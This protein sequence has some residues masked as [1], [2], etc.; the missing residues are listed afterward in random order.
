M[1]NKV[2]CHK[3]PFETDPDCVN[4]PLNLLSDLQDRSQYIETMQVYPRVIQ[5]GV[6]GGSMSLV[7]PKKKAYLSSDS[8][9][10]LPLTCV[11]TGFQLVPSAGIS[12]LIDSAVMRTETGGVIAQ[13]QHSSEL[14]VTID[15]TTPPQ[16]RSGVDSVHHGVSFTWEG[17][18]GSKMNANAD[19]R[20]VLPGQLRL[21][22]DNYMLMSPADVVGR[23][24]C[25]PNCVSAKNDLLLATTFENTPEFSITLG[26]L[27]PGFFRTHFQF[28]L[29]LLAEEVIIDIN[30]SQNGN[31]GQNDR[32]VCAPDLMQATPSCITS[33]GVY[34]LGQ[35]P[36]ALNGTVDNVVAP[37]N[38]PASRGTG[39]RIMV[40]FKS[41]GEPENIRI[42]DAGV[43][44]E[45]EDKIVFGD[46]D[47]TERMV[48]M[49][50]HN[51]KETVWE[52]NTNFLVISGGSDFVQGDTYTVVNPSNP[53]L[54]FKIVATNVDEG[55]LVQC[56]LDKVETN[57]NLSLPNGTPEP[58]K[59][60]KADGTS[61]GAY[62]VLASHIYTITTTDGTE[63]FSKGTELFVQG[64]ED[65][66]IV[67]YVSQVDED[68]NPT[69][70]YV[71]DNSSFQV[72]VILVEPGTMDASS[73]E[74]D[75]IVGNP[76][77][78]TSTTGL[79]HDPVWSFDTYS[80][81]R[82]NLVTGKVSLATDLVFYLNGKTE[83]DLD[84]ML[85]NGYGISY[86]QYVDVL[87]TLSKNDSVDDY[88]VKESIE[89]SRQ[90]GFSNEV[91]RNI[92]F[93]VSPSGTQPNENFPYYN[94]PKLNPLLNKYCSMGS[95]AMNGV[96][97]QV[98]V[99]SVPYYSQAIDT[100]LRMLSELNKCHGVFYIPKPVYSAWPACRQLDNPTATS[101][102][103]DL[104]NVT[105]QPG[106]T[107]LD[108]WD[109]DA[110]GEFTATRRYEI[111]ERK[112]GVANQL[113]H[114]I[115]QKWA[116][117]QGHYNGCSFMF[118][119][120]PSVPGNGA[121]IGNNA[122]D[123]RYTHDSTFNPYYG[124]SARMMLF[125]EVERVL[126]IKDGII[127]VTT[128]AF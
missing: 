83:R 100:D 3:D 76:T 77:E 70:L 94:K 43:G 117:G 56:T 32:C 85:T 8:R 38:A 61:S 34:T 91:L 42:L 123:I 14:Y 15:H 62:L 103:V 7:L 11:D 105:L 109:G 98:N 12:G 17:A 49:P 127:N 93:S 29:A 72:G 125:G 36:A 30:F 9:L 97:F 21:K 114:G 60:L 75:T 126:T 80:A 73:F 26:R 4:D 101:T 39:L 33:L 46:D 71:V 82:V 99:N 68:S 35:G 95:L 23:N 10:I 89:Y 87:S 54:N 55:A 37:V 25:K 18:S 112:M 88:G 27:F 108:N 113:W 47:W 57:D 44:Y 40:D 102:H 20:E 124:G 81:G 96:Q 74:V 121:V 16:R 120:D 78:Y 59:V 5:D 79:G 28:P 22:S 104:D 92:M 106:F 64:D 118:K 41:N 19:D 1:S 128:A 67:A 122:V 6:E 52:S 2:D 58:L 53:A 66:T 107:T 115:P 84:Q 111:N 13:S 48:L 45:A 116:L 24:N 86:T 110:N 51:I 65:E 90:I 69:E 31:F 50:A 63:S 119:D